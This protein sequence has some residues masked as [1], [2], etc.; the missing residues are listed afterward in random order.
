[1]NDSSLIARL[2]AMQHTLRNV[3]DSCNAAAAAC[4]ADGAKG[5]AMATYMVG[6]SIAVFASAIN[7]YAL[8]GAEDDAESD[9]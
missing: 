9:Y 8:R 7:E 2:I 1:M 3:V 4:D 5:L 6:E